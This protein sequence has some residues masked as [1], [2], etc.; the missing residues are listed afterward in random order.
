MRIPVAKEGAPFIAALAVVLLLALL[1]A[2]TQEGGLR[3]LPPGILA[4]LLLFVVY[5]FRD[6]ERRPPA[7]PS[8]V[9]SPADGK[10]L[11]VRAVEDEAFMGGPSTRITIFLSIFNVHV[12][13]APVSG[14]VGAYQY[15]PGDYLA[16]WHE[17]ASTHNE[18]ATLGIRGSAGPV[19]VRQIAGLVARRIVTYPREGDT[20]ERGDRIGLIRFGS[21]VDLFVPARW[22]IEAKPGDRVRGGETVLAVEGGSP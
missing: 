2:R 11:D 6:P 3:T 17:K 22:R 18:R 8:L 16:A 19:V 1:W 15:H 12:Q 21:R 13:R 5:F 14:S 4:V 10:I 9:V 7:D 20:V